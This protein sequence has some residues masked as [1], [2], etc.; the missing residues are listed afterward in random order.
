MNKIITFLC[1]LVFAAIIFG[2]G[3]FQEFWIDGF[4]S[5]S[6]NLIKK[7]TFS[8]EDYAKDNKQSDWQNVI[9]AT[10]NYCY[11][12]KSRSGVVV[13]GLSKIT[14]AVDYDGENNICEYSVLD[15]ADIFYDELNKNLINNHGII[16]KAK[17][18]E[19]RYSIDSVFFTELLK[20]TATPEELQHI[21]VRVKNSYFITYEHQEIK[22]NYISYK[23]NL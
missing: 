1:V 13:D 10:K 9:S 14:T 4:K 2:L 18:M 19:I 23:V 22:F 17:L 15:E 8:D 3:A 11:R 6:Y 5:K 7:Y 12:I 20:T 16:D 21:R